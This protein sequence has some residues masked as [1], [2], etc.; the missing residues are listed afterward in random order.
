MKCSDA[1]VR[2]IQ[3]FEGLRLQ[4]YLDSAGIPTIGFGTIRY[5]NGTKVKLGDTCT[6]P[7]ADDWFRHDLTRFELDVDA[8]TIDG[9]AQRQFDALCSFTYNLGTAAYK[10]STLRKKVNLNP[11]DPTIR[12]EFMKWHNA[13]GKPVEGLW[14]RRHKEADTYAGVSTPCPPMPR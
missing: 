6:E 8:A 5:P 4:A 10:G 1:G 12:A 11:A 7:D 3:G 13:D 14:R 9:V 2:L